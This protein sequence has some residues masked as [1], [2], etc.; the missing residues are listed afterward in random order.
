M[1]SLQSI[2]VIIYWSL[3][4]GTHEERETEREE[5]RKRVRRGKSARIIRV[6]FLQS[7]F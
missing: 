5:N 1:K 6:I 2:T 4:E 7:K 3:P